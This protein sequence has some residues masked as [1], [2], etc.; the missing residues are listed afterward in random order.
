VSIDAGVRVST[1][2]IPSS[3]AAPDRGSYLTTFEARGDLYN[4]A[5]R[6]DPQA[7]ESERALLIEY[8][9]VERSHRV[10]DAPA[11]GGFLAD[12][13]K[14]Q[15][16][17]TRQI[18]C[19]EP[20][21][22]FAQGLSPDYQCHVAPLHALPLPDGSVERV[23]SLAGLHHLEDKRP[24]FGE[25]WRVLRPGGVFALADA[26]EG[27]PVAAFLNGPVD[28]LTQTGHDGRFL[29]QGE[30]A[31][32]LRT[33]GFTDVVEHHRGCPWRF[34]SRV[35]MARYCRLLFGMV[36]ADE[37]TVADELARHFRI[38]SDHHSTRLPWSLVYAVGV[39]PG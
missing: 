17:D 7:R 13:L 23:G 16:S 20:S 35:A 6:V 21:A 9:R 38:E 5:A 14:A 28:R 30:A 36:L 24:F 2:S 34:A 18:V 31:N 39:K 4:D 32:L 37:K 10:L 12:G 19:V 3:G 27:T 8:L 29:R 15:V 26:M 25:A 22:R 1:S 33:V 11:G